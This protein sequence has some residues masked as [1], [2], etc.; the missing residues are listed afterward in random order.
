MSINAGSIVPLR[1]GFDLNETSTGYTRR[2]F[3]RQVW[4]GGDAVVWPGWGG[5]TVVRGGWGWGG[6]MQWCDQVRG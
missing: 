2:R 6:E 3:L 5:D 4:G 1:V